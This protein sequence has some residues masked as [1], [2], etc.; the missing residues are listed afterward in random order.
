ML[1]AGFGVT[2][3]AINPNTHTLYTSNHEDAS[4]SVIDG[5]TCNSLV[6]TG[7]DQKPPKLPA[8]D[9][10]G[11]IVVDPTVDT[12]YIATLNGLAVIPLTH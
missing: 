8:R 5:A 10:P 7:C 1:R 2:S 11:P 12:A 6:H 4:V 3:L 9:Y